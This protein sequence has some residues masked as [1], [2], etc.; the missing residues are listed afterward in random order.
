MKL[1]AIALDYDGTI[2]TDG[3]MD[4]A[5][6]AAL[7]AARRKG[8]S[9]ILVTGRR[10]DELRRVAGGLHVFDAVV[11]EN[12]AVLFFPD[13]GRH[14]TFGRPPA[15][16]L[17]AELRGLGVPFTVGEIIVETD[18]QWA[19][20]ALDALRRLEQPL[21]M[22]FNRS[23]LMLLPQGISK[24]TGLRQALA[25]L[26][27]SIHNTI[28]VGDAENDHDLLDA[29]E[30]GAAAGWGSVA[31][32]AV[33]D[34]V[35]Q[36]TGPAATA[37][38]VRRVAGQLRLSPAQMGRRRLTLGYQD[39]GDPVSLAVRGR[40]MII[41]G[42]PGT[43]KS[44]LAGLI[45]EQLILQGYCMCLID[46]E[47]DYRSLESLPG[48]VV[49]GGDDPPPTVRELS[50]ALRHPDVSVLIDLSKAPRAQ[51]T[52]YLRNLLP[53]V[54]AFRRRTGLP[55]KILIDEAHYYLGEPEGNALV[56]PELAGYIL[57]SYRVSALA[58]NVRR[59]HDAVILVTRETD[60]A[61]LAALEAMCAERGSGICDASVLQ[62]LQTSEAA[63]LPPPNHGNGGVPPEDAVKRFRLAPRMTSHVRHRV[64]YLDMGVPESQAFVFSGPN[65][66]DGR[67]RTLR[68]FMALLDHEPAP[69]IEGHLRRRDFSRW[70]LDVFRDGPLS[71]HVRRLERR[72]GL[73]DTREL[74]SDIA[75][76]IRARYDIA[77]ERV[78]Q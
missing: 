5:V 15:S 37:D 54:T 10:L 47:G 4:P 27:L 31:L 38:Y 66:V 16:A 30:V 35:I 2:A 71:A 67:A 7:P 45:C 1:T 51:K 77:D 58:Q 20:A 36:G 22:S 65:G 11:A 49:L 34:D 53:L 6:R 21:V 14:A 50:R 39:S 48:V 19:P 57:V 64:K 76:S 33:A 26:R 25:A 9:L 23:R 12:G 62:T 3:R 8:I 74:A 46:P 56:D 43:G 41:T 60:P 13:S 42:E 44:W 29:C 40:T 32:R 59:S 73:D 52:A 68:E 70:L 78:L 75:Q 28:G 69:T 55:H 17:L 63:L 24:S 61:E 72:A 18:A